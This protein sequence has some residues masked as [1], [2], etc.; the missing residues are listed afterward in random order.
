M[1]EPM[2]LDRIGLPLDAPER[3]MLRLAHRTDE[4]LSAMRTTL[5]PSLLAAASRNARRGV[6]DIALYELDR[7]FLPEPGAEL[8]AEPRRLGIVLRG[9]LWSSDWNV[10]PEEARAD[11]YT[12]KGI[13]EELLDV[14]GIRDAVFGRA[15]HP[16][17]R[18]GRCAEVF[19][20]SGVHGVRDGSSLGVLGEVRAEVAEAH[21]LPPGI[22]ACE[23]DA[24]S[25]VARAALHKPYSSVPMLPPV[26]RDVALVVA[27][28]EEHCAAAVE[29]A[30]REAAGPLLQSI[31]LFDVYSD[32]TRLG[33]GRKGLA[34]SLELRA[35]DRSLTSEEADKI[36]ARITEHLRCKLG[37]ELR[38]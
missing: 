3:N 30:T 25:L 21:D 5:L 7:V 37:A 17:F 15:S 1:I 12:L 20:P 14:L 24:E 38:S 2:E 35:A 29:A 26:L 31:T 28:D 4:G 22:F 27:D 19:V 34:F 23:L 11:F 10:R 9:S 6:R 18:P 36:I 13:V 32:P 8:P 33:P 16:T